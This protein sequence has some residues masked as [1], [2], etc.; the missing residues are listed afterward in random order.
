MSFLGEE[1]SSNNLIYRGSVKDIYRSLNSEHVVFSFSDRYSIFDWGEMPDLIDDKGKALSYMGA[2]FFNYLGDCQNW[3]NWKEPNHLSGAG[4]DLLK[5][6]R[7]NGVNHHFVKMSEEI[8]YGLE[9][10]KVDVPCVGKNSPYNYDLYKKK[11]N[12][13]LI[14]LEVIFRFG[15]PVGSSLVSRRD[16]V[17][18]GDTF[19]KPIIEFSSKLESIDRYME[20]SEAKD[21]AGLTD[22]EMSCLLDTT[23]L[24]AS[25]LKDFFTDHSI[26][27]WDGKFEFAF[28]A[29]R[30]LIL[31]DSIGP[32]ELRLICDGESLSKEYLRQFYSESRWKKALKKAQSEDSINVQEYVVNTLNEPPLTLDSEYKNCFSSLYKSLTNLFYGQENKKFET[33][34]FADVIKKIKENK[35]KRSL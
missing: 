5:A 7:D 9:V 35:N 4:Q 6:F 11:V 31:V 34:E 3:I 1:V 19:N 10:K 21:I 16:D 12:N 32:D 14:P 33:L 24:I 25:R 26:E 13:T 30:E 22:V 18:V 28:G 23:I 27:L 8:E 29:N 20:F 17:K 2:F 15:V